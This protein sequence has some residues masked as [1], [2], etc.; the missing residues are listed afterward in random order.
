MTTASDVYAFGVCLM[1]L[2]TGQQ[3]IDHMRLE[4]YNLIEW[5]KPRFKVGGVEDVVDTALGEDYDK[6][7]LKLM[8]EVALACTAVSKNDRP[9][10]KV[11]YIHN[12]SPVP[13]PCPNHNSLLITVIYLNH[14]FKHY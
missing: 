1:E 8:V 10:M 4:E 5:V 12:Q 11:R 3:S 6:E 2:I 14:P 7:V 13:K 9:T